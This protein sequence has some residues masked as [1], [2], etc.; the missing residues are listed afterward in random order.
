MIKLFHMA[1]RLAVIS[2]LLSFSLAFAEEEIEAQVNPNPQ[3]ELQERLLEVQNLLTERRA[4]Q[5]RL[6]RQLNNNGTSSDGG[7]LSSQVEALNKEVSNLKKT[8][9]H[10]VVGGADLETIEE[11]PQEFNW[12]KEMTLVTKPLVDTLK[13]LT[14]KPR[15][16]EQ[17]K[18]AIALNQEK[19]AIIQKALTELEANLL[20]EPPK[21]LRVAMQDVKER[22]E[23]R[24]AEN[25]REFEF[26]SFQLATL[27]GTNISWFET[28]RDKTTEFLTGRGLTLLIAVIASVMMW[29]FTR[30][31]L[32]LVK[33]LPRGK[34]NKKSLKLKYRLA[35]YAFTLLTTLLI[36]TIVI[37]VFYIRGDILLLALSL[38]FL[39]FA[40]LRMRN[41]LPQ[42]IAEA[43]LLL[44][45]GGLREG[46]RTIFNGLP[47]EVCTINI[48]S[49][50]R[51]PELEGVIRLPISA[52]HEMIS[53]PSRDESWFPT[54]KGDFVL[55]PDSVMGEVIMQTPEM[56]QLKVKGGMH[57]Y[58]PTTDFISMG[59]LNLSR[60]DS[61][62]ITTVFGIDY[63]LQ[64]IALLEVPNAFQIAIQEAINSEG[65]ID[66]LN[67][68]I[69]ELK[70]AGAS[71]LDYL[72]IINVKP[73]AASL[74][75]KLERLLQR[76]CIQV[77]SEEG[78]GIPFPQVTIH[79]AN[80]KK[81]SVVLP[82]TV[83]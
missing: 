37:L 63:D 76:T 44:N 24:L 31:L 18:S 9:E 39:A 77:C 72:V 22:W 47:W 58:L 12:Q 68:V 82:K 41:F 64:D 2:L 42:Y 33:W 74:Y 17:L 70:G 80:P 40:V 79:Q 78:W 5:T 56:V 57:H 20:L 34:K 13:S 50:L 3:L 46:E 69:V 19:K 7:E 30:F 71:S 48:Y 60:G 15:K 55:L 21:T 36:I 29:M 35:S 32:W 66:H 75:F 10:L 8:F 65:L 62:V 11:E 16:I 27:Q 54:S 53:R 1:Q 73:T 43:K 83:G 23:Q 67:E 81:D 28:I 61:F 4:L 45:V 14:E 25:S 49:I 38:L 59:V 26:V 51:N 52:L 6:Q